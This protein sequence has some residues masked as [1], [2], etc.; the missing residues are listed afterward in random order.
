MHRTRIMLLTALLLAICCAGSAAAAGDVAVDGKITISSG[1]TAVVADTDSSAGDRLE[2]SAPSKTDYITLNTSEGNIAFNGSNATSATVETGGI[3]GLYDVDAGS[4]ELEIETSGGYVKVIPEQKQPYRINT[5]DATVDYDGVTVGDISKEFEVI[6]DNRVDILAPTKLSN[7]KLLA[8]DNFATPEEY[9]TY[10]TTSADGTVQ[11]EYKQ[12]GLEN[13]YLKEPAP[14]TIS[15]IDPPDGGQTNDTDPVL[16]AD[17]KSRDFSYDGYNYTATFRDLDRN[18]QA[19][20]AD[21]TTNA[22]V[23]GLMDK[24]T[25]GENNWSINVSTTAGVTKSTGK[26][27]FLT[28]D[29]LTIRNGSD[30]NQILTDNV[31]FTVRFISDDGIVE[32]KTSTGSVS[33]AG[34]DRSKRYLVTVRPDENSDFVYRRIIVNNIGKESSVYLLKNQAS[35][36]SVK[37]ELDNPTGAFPPT[38]TELFV[39]K[40]ITRDFNDDGK[41]ETQYAVVAG[42][43]FGSSGSFPLVVENGQR[44]RLRVESRDGSTS[45][46]LGAYSTQ[47]PERVPLTIE[48]I[49]PSGDVDAG[50]AVT[51]SVEGNQVVVRYLD[52][53]KST[54]SVE[55]RVVDDSGN[56]VVPNNTRTDNRFADFYDLPGG[57]NA[58]YTVDW[59]VTTESGEITSGSFEA[60]RVVE[61]VSK[62][63]DADPA[64]LELLSYVAI[65]AS[66]GLVVLVSAQ[67][68][69]LTGTAVAS[70]L[71]VIGTVAIPTPVLGIAGAISV[72]LPLGRR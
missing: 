55:Y 29:L 49:E 36:S 66:M 56:T 65:L 22:S 27:N 5:S 43:V 28:P 62:R 2:F 24:A 21:K 51:G 57:T 26:L 60:G 16:S 47:N 46:V 41:N 13:I 33:L 50:R 52:P 6:S 14:I 32:R 37:F 12:Q 68:A 61:G 8:V 23:S 38:E 9:L 20:F 64:W 53:S 67:L 17:V 44:Y 30:P 58:T 42:D 69:P 25:N 54:K 35:T 1:D 10:D 71:T 70:I 31:S 34:L 45:R 59:T 18:V 48:R 19:G 63:I 4:V 15:N 7:T 11:I 72:L 3:G 39:E 40:P